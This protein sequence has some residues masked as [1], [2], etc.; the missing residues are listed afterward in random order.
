MTREFPTIQIN[1]PLI[2][3]ALDLCAKYFYN[4]WDCLMI[5]AASSAGCA[6]LFSEDMQDGHTIENKLTIKNI[7]NMIKSPRNN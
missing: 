1:Q 5:A 6:Y 3:E 2:L 4:Y 7:F